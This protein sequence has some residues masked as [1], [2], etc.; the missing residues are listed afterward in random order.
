M[1]CIVPFVT[2][3]CK[4]IAFFSEKVATQQLEIGTIVF[5]SIDVMENDSW[6]GKELPRK[7][8]P[9]APLHNIEP[10]L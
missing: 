10:D 7:N 4:L 2:S 1:K 3:Y 6:R 9:T 5:I 8:I